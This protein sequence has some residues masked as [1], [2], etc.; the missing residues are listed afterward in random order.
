MND[1]DHG[2]MADILILGEDVFISIEVKYEKR[3]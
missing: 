3:Y 1:V 2:E